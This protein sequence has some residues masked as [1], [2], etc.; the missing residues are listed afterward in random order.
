MTY[1][2]ERI[3][4]NESIPNILLDKCLIYYLDS[5]INNEQAIS[6]IIYGFLVNSNYST[7]INFLSTISSK[8]SNTHLKISKELENE[9]EKINEIN[10]RTFINFCKNLKLM[11]KSI[12]SISIKIKLKLIKYR[13]KELNKILLIL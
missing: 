3:N 9:T 1:N 12:I 8:I 6:Q 4:H 2:P 10:E 11:K 5:F 7:D 13:L